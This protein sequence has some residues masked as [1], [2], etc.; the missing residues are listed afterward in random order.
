VAALGKPQLEVAHP[1]ND[2]PVGTGEGNRIKI[3]G[4]SDAA[5]GAYPWQVSLQNLRSN[6]ERYHMCGGTLID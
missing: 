5:P 4:G 3:I 2:I 6:G 1:L